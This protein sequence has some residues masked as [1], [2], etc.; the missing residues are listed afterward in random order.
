MVC[1]VSAPTRQWPFWRSTPC[2]PGTLRRSTSSE[3]AASR[4]FISGI[5][6]WPPAISLASSPPSTSAAMASWS[7]CGAV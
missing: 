5:S 4:S 3:G 6:E 2:R 7:D 1:V